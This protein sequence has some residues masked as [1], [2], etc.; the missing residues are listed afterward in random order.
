[1]SSLR[2]VNVSANELKISWE[3]P[4]SGGPVEFYQVTV[5]TSEQ[6]VSDDSTDDLSILI[7]E[8]GKFLMM[9]VALLITIC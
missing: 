1:M 3:G 5:S 7:D 2:A 6:Q 9:A 4:E 8:L